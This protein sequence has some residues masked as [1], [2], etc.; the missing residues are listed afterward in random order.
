MEYYS[1]IG[2]SIFI[3]YNVESFIKSYFFNL[4]Q[5][6]VIIFIQT[7]R[8]IF[9]IWIQVEYSLLWLSPILILYSDYFGTTFFHIS[10]PYNI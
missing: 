10:L 3:I 8:G 7:K 9:I 1:I 2:C 5:N 6:F 4:Y